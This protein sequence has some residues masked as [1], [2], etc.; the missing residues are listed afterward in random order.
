[1]LDE[2]LSAFCGLVDLHNILQMYHAFRSFSL[3][4]CL[5][6]REKT[7]NV[8]EGGFNWNI[9]GTSVMEVTG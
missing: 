2:V 4:V 7:E 3:D 6:S 9:I 5:F 8:T 1:M